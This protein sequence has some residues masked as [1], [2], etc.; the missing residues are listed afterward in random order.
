MHLSVTSAS[1]PCHVV[2]QQR[3]SS[4]RGMEDGRCCRRASIAKREP[5]GSA[6]SDS[7]PS[8]RRTD[9]RCEQSLH[10]AGEGDRNMKAASPLAM[11]SASSASE[12]PPHKRGTRSAQVDLRARLELADRVELEV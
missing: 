6:A 8:S 5:E 10:A 12:L 4:N 11:G 1:A 9:A 7:P 3:E 2:S